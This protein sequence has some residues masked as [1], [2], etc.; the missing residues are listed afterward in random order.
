MNS[1]VKITIFS[2]ICIAVSVFFLYTALRKMQKKSKLMVAQNVF[3]IP[4]AVTA[5]FVNFIEPHNDPMLGLWGIIM[6]LTAI[7]TGVGYLVF[8]LVMPAVNLAKKREAHRPKVYW[9]NVIVLIVEFIL[10]PL[11]LI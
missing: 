9:A 8:A 4:L 1:T 7:P 5:I 3:N 11:M 6:I 10:A 2:V